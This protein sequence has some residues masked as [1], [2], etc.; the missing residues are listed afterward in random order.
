LNETLE[1]I[2]STD[3]AGKKLSGSKLYKLKLPACMP[4]AEFWSVIVYD[5]QTHL[6]IKTDQPWP[7]VHSNC[8][9]LIVNSDGTVDILF[10]P[11]PPAGKETNWIKTI[12]RKE[13]HALIRIYNLKESDSSGWKPGEIVVIQ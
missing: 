6:I 12:P 1:N 4:V 3:S 10:G 9:K 2:I 5:S 7:S 13:W 8:K 11:D